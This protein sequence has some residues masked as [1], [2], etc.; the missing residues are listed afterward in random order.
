[1]AEAEQSDEVAAS[2]TELAKQ[3]DALGNAVISAARI[4][5]K[6]ISEGINVQVGREPGPQ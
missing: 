5:A 1:M 6:A 3:V 2:I 4:I